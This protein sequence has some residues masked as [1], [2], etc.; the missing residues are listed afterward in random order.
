MSSA[1]QQ[2]E[3]FLGVLAQYREGL[4]SCGVDTVHKLTRLSEEELEEAMTVAGITKS[5]HRLLLSSKVS[6]AKQT[7]RSLRS[8][9]RQ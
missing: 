6:L 1:A 2:M 5:G 3:V 8:V 4:A 7:K 9:G